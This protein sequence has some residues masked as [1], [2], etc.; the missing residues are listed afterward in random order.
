[1]ANNFNTPQGTREL[2][3]TTPMPDGGTSCFYRTSFGFETDILSPDGFLVSR[4]SLAPDLA[5]LQSTSQPSLVHWNKSGQ[6][7]FMSFNPNAK[8]IKR[9]FRDTS[10][11]LTTGYTLVAGQLRPT[12]YYA[13]DPESGEVDQTFVG[14]WDSGA[15]ATVSTYCANGEA[16]LTRY[17]EDGTALG[18]HFFKDGME[19]PLPENLNAPHIGDDGS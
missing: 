10:V 18:Q 7:T 17:N 15:V 2:L 3:N 13:A 8:Q 11:P 14:Y 5:P 6:V 1:M 19:V 16:W 12:S 9:Y 4:S